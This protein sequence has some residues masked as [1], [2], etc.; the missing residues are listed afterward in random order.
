MEKFLIKRPSTSISY[1]S[2]SENKKCKLSETT[3]NQPI[4]EELEE[5]TFNFENQKKKT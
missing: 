4:N 1:E 2:T 3:T 5:K